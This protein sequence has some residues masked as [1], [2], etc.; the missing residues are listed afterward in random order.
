M[1]S[2]EDH[3]NIDDLYS[4]SLKN[5]LKS[6]ITYNTILNKTV[7]AIQNIPEYQKLKDP[8]SSTVDH[9]LI[10]VICNIVEDYTNNKTKQKLDKKQL[11]NDIITRVYGLNQ[12]EITSL[13]Q[14]IEFLFNNDFIKRTRLWKY[15]LK[16]AQKYTIKFT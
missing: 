7:T 16:K 4:G 3:V 1:S 5:S 13:N 11:V 6:H 12:N 8:N 9:E 14:Q 10:K 2:S 15:I